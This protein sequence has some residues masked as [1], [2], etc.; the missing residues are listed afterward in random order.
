[1]AFRAAMTGH[2][3]YSTLHTN[4]A[5]GAI[6][7]LLDIGLKPGSW[8]ATSSASS[9]S[10]SC[11]GFARTAR[12]GTAERHRAAA[13]GHRGYGS[14]Q[15]FRHRGCDGA[16]TWLPGPPLDHGDHPLR[17]GHGRGPVPEP[18]PGRTA[19]LATAKGFRPLADDGIRRVLAGDTSLEEI[20]RVVDLTER[21]LG[22]TRMSAYAYRAVDASGRLLR[23]ELAAASEAELDSPAAADRPAAGH[24]PAAQQAPAACRGH[25]HQTGAS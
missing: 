9:P 3:V 15:I 7:R 23:G 10:G 4:S 5:L 19:G 25:R 16:T 14:V 2:Q 12:A 17:P 20:A 11:A 1:M 6:P 21:A 13:D 8:P 18:V 22:A 24:L